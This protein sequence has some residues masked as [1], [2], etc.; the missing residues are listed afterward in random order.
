MGALPEGQPAE[1]ISFIGVGPPMPDE[2]E[3]VG[4]SA[5]LGHLVGSYVPTAIPL[6]VGD[7]RAGELLM[8]NRAN[9]LERC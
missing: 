4:I 6:Q 3:G 2:P 1:P 9:A 8:A 5:Q 7:R